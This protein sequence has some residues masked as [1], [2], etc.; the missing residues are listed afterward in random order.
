MGHDNILKRCLSTIEAQ[1]VMNEFHE[2]TIGGYFAIK[3]THKK[4]LDT[5]Y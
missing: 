2:G 1:K 5:R 3:I 4:I